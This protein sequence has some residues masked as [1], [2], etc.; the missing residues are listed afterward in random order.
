MSLDRIINRQ[1]GEM[2]YGL[3][4]GSVFVQMNAAQIE[5][6]QCRSVSECAPVGT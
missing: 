5:I 1:K 6:N 4:S 2:R 3:A